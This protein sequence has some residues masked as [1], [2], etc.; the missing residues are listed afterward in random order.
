[1][2]QQKGVFVSLPDLPQSSL[3]FY[4][5]LLTFESTKLKKKVK[6]AFSC[7]LKFFSFND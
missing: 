5:F 2:Q 4:T 3:Y 6:K 7:Y 1:M